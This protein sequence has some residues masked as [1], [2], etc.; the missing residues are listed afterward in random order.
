MQK[1]FFFLLLFGLSSSFFGRLSAQEGLWIDHLSFR[2]ARDVVHNGDEVYVSTEQGVFIYSDAEFSLRKLTKINGLNDFDISDIA[3]NTKRK[4]L[5]IAYASGNVDVYHPSSGTTTNF[6]DIKRNTGVFGSK[7]INYSQAFGDSIFFACDFGIVV[8]DL[9]T[10]FFRDTYLIASDGGQVQVNGVWAD[11]ETNRIYA[12]TA[13]GLITA[14]LSDP[15]R[16][17][18]VWTPLAGAHERPIKHMT[19]FN[20]KVIY[21]VE[22]LDPNVDSVFVVENGIRTP[23]IGPNNGRIYEVEAGSSGLEVVS[24]FNAVLYNDQLQPIQNVSVNAEDLKDFSPRKASFNL[25]DQRFWIADNSLGLVRNFD[26]FYNQIIFP[27]GPFSNSFFHVTSSGRKL[28]TSAGGVSDAW[29]SNFNNDGAFRYNGTDTWSKVD[30]EGLE[31]VR[32]ILHITVDPADPEH[33]FMSSWGNGLVEVKDG[34]VNTIYTAQ[35]SDGAIQRV[36][37]SSDS[38]FLIGGTAYDPDRN[39][40]ITNA[41]TDNPLVVFRADGSWKNFSLGA[42]G[43]NSV[44]IRDI[45]YTSRDQVWI[46]TRNAGIIVFEEAIPNNNVG[47]LNGVSGT[48]N[49]P[50]VVVTAMAEDQDGEIW[51]GTEEGLGVVYTPY[52]IFENGLNY[53]AQPILIETDEGIV[54]RLLNG[55]PISD[56]EVDGANKKWISTSNNGVFYFG[57]DGTEEIHHFTAENSP[58]LSNNVLDIAIEDETG[59]VYFSTDK[60]LISF[61]GSATKGGETFSK[62]YAYPNPVRPGYQ[63]PIFISGLLTNAQMKITDLSGNLVYEATAEG[64]QAQWNGSNFSGER[65]KSGVY[66]VFLTNDDGSETEMTK[67]LIVN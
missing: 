18:G 66:L 63:G 11:R 24:I 40:W 27:E 8:L 59:F 60:G 50:G 39:L 55:L 22:T 13:E 28:Y 35:N 45:L 2:S 25:A 5:I 51:I 26:L 36:N 53:D 17:F 49:L 1:N 46:Q 10:G 67:I 7:T 34:Q 16:F 42:A 61:K 58:L 20:G 19:F 56:I 65:V 3:Y 29:K 12:A 30:P 23:L 6:S 44:S 48:G 31:D 47:V 54:E 14:K 52:N 21:S 38:I 57:E 32:D 64:G 37:G 9:K 15:L 41:L 62:V 33:Y 4:E 43:G